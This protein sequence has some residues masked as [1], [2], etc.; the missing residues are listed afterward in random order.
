[1]VYNTLILPLFEYCNVVVGHGKSAI[2]TRPQRLQNRGCI[3]L[4]W[5]RYSDSLDIFRELKWLSIEERVNFHTGLMMFKCYQKSAQNIYISPSNTQRRDK[6]T[7]LVGPSLGT[8]YHLTINLS[9]GRT[10]LHTRVLC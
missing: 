6:G 2:L 5:N 4:G 1:M 8:P 3:I 7:A 10:V 9:V